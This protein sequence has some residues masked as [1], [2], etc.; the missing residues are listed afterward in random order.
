MTR[1]SRSSTAPYNAP[2][3]RRSLAPRANGGRPR[4][5]S[6]SPSTPSTL[7]GPSRGEVFYEDKHTTELRFQKSFV[8][9][10]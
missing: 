6:L 10:R 5:S 9:K 4:R 3:V 1:P 7:V 2:F 8:D